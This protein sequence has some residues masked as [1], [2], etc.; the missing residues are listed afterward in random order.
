MKPT[1]PQKWYRDPMVW[2]GLLHGAAIWAFMA[3]FLSIPSAWISLACGFFIGFFLYLVALGYQDYRFARAI[4]VGFA[5]NI[6]LSS[7]SAIIA[8]MDQ[9]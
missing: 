6:F 1:C 7:L 9:S 2:L 3:S 4:L 5:I 8:L